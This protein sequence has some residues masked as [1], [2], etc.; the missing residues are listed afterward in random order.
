MADA[1]TVYADIEARTDNLRQE[2]LDALASIDGT[3]T[4]E[5][6]ATAVSSEIED[7]I[8]A[9]DG[10]VDVDVLA[11][12]T[13]AESEIDGL[14]PSAPVE[15][16]VEANTEQ[17]EEQIGGLGDQ[18]AG[19]I[20]GMGD[21]GAAGALDAFGGAAFGLGSAAGLAATGGLAALA[22]GVGFAASEAADA[23]SVIAQLDQMVANMGANAGVTSPELQSLASDIQAT[24]GFSD[25]AVMSGEAMVLMFENVRNVAGQ[26]IFDRAIESAA[27]LARS[28]MFSGDFAS[29]ARTLG[30]ALDDPVAGMG[31]LRRAGIQLTEAQQAQITALQESGDVVGAQAALLDIVEGK[32]A[33]LAESY[34]DTLAGDVDKAK[35][36]LGEAAE[37][38]G[39]SVLPA[40]ADM[41]GLVA[42]SAEGWRWL[43]EESDRFFQNQQLQGDWNES[44]D[45]DLGKD[46]TGSQ[47]L[48]LFIE[49]LFNVGGHAA[50]AKAMIDGLSKSTAEADGSFDGAAGAAAGF[51]SSLQF[52]DE[53]VQGYLDGVYRVPEA[54]RALRGAFENVQAVLADPSA[55]ADDLAVALQGVATATAGLGTATGDMSAAV[56]IATFGLLGLEGQGGRSEGQIKDLDATLRALPGQT[57]PGVSVPGAVEGRTQV[58]RLEDALLGLPH[59]RRV[60][61]AVDIARAGFD[62]L[63]ADL[64]RLDAA[65]TYRAAVQ[66]SNREHGGP[67]E[68]GRPYVVGEQRP[69]LFVPDVD[70]RIEP[71]VPAGHAG[72]GGTVQHFHF[73]QYVGD[74]RDLARAV[75]E[76]VR[77]HERAAR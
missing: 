1:G 22:G 76:A 63:L 4:A 31:R 39:A 50:Q 70:G 68:A 64:N 77:D 45:A 42:E 36:Q 49:D 66:V 10:T 17:A 71:R 9:V 11:D 59:Q 7:A 24:A 74:R 25:E 62:A 60:S 16:P 34:G 53:R 15:V 51:S 55:T 13:T 8:S 6:D 20:D 23:E 54:E 40:L 5:A 37:T 27:D 30:R 72:S 61:V 52:L 3:V 44:N 75:T 12:T 2:I 38:I 47:R 56:D 43:F 73:P 26:P 28:P 46:P 19:L 33:G 18:I 21:G 58:D 29:A 35:E 69:E 67:V 48:T 65:D 57:S 41:T 32:V 14:E